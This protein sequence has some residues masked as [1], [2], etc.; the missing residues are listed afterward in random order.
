MKYEDA[1]RIIEDSKK[2]SGFRVS[3]EVRKNGC[4]RSDHFPEGDED[5]I[6]NE[7]VAWGLARKFSMAD[8]EWPIVNVYVIYAIDFTPVKGYKGRMFNIHPPESK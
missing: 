2:N 8:M 6:E 7:E 1:M 3:F 5:V 4:L